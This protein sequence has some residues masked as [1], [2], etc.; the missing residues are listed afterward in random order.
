L[1]SFL[2]FTSLDGCINITLMGTHPGCH[3]QGYGSMLI[4]RLLQRA[5]ALGFNK[6]GVMTVPADMKPAY[7]AT[8]GFYKKHGFVETKRYQELWE[9]GAVELVRI[10]SPIMQ[11]TS[12]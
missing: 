8:I 12:L 2:M 5:L 6:I 7:Q 1:R 10:L 4:E 3:G 9:S 11:N